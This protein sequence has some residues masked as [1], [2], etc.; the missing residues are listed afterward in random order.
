MPLI[1]AD[2]IFKKPLLLEELD[3]VINLVKSLPEPSIASDKIISSAPENIEFCLQRESL[4]LNY[5]LNESSTKPL[6][7]IGTK[8]LVQCIFCII[9]SSTDLLSVHFDHTSNIDLTERVSHFKDNTCLEVMIIGGDP[10]DRFKE[11]SEKTLRNILDLLYTTAEKLKI[12]IHI[13]NQKLL[14]NNKPNSLYDTYAQVYD[15]ILEQ[16]DNL[17]FNLYKKSL[18]KTDFPIACIDKFKDENPKITELPL[19][20]FAVALMTERIIYDFMGKYARD[21]SHNADLKR[22]FQSEVKFIDLLKEMFCHNVFSVY[23]NT[24]NFSANYRS[25][26]CS[27]FAFDLKSKN[28]VMLSKHIPVRDEKLRNVNLI[29]ASNYFHCYDGIRNVPITPSLTESFLSNCSATK[30]LLDSIDITKFARYFNYPINNLTSYHQL[31]LNIIANFIRHEDK[32]IMDVKHPLNINKMLVSSGFF[33]K[34]IAKKQT[35]LSVDQIM[36]LLNNDSPEFTELD[37]TGSKFDEGNN[38]SN[39]LMALRD[40]IRVSSLIFSGSKLDLYCLFE[41][42]PVNTSLRSLKIIGD[43]KEFDISDAVASS[44]IGQ[45]KTL[46]LLDLRDTNL[47]E[48]CVNLGVGEDIIKYMLTNNHRLTSILY[49]EGDMRLERIIKPILESKTKLSED[50]TTVDANSNALN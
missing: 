49:R 46:I 29:Q 44:G 14:E 27:N 15:D 39:V 20:E 30:P 6:T 35:S 19:C 3:R 37:V 12:N 41:L 24:Y 9:S 32:L 5:A 38:R 33:N 28:I 23:D 11:M 40:N 4:H 10:R 26:T 43:Y 45:N 36:S 16:A 48:C 42:L 13:T 34:D 2:E 50:L 47:L 25:T 22:I 7:H 17:Y 31:E 8:Q 18:N 1:I 21:N